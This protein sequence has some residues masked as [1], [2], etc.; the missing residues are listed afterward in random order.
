MNGFLI[1]MI[2]LLVAVLIINITMLI[3]AVKMLPIKR[4]AES[5]IWW[6]DK[7]H[8]CAYREKYYETLMPF[9]KGRK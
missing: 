2:I 7:C 3:E 1:T 6:R 8:S 4:L 9:E 5:E